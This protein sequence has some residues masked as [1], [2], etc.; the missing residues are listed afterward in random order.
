MNTLKIIITLLVLTI[1]TA[2]AQ[3]N[4]STIQ[5]DMSSNNMLEGLE[6]SELEITF[7]SMMIEHHKGAIDMAQW[8]LERTQNADIKA[9]AEAIIAAQDPEIEQMTAWL[10]AWYKQGVD[11]HS[12]MMMQSEMDL[13]MGNMAAS[14]N[15]DAAFLQ[16]MSAHHNSAI[17]MAQF[18]LLGATHPELRELAKNIIVTQSQEI[19]QYQN[20]LEELP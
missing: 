16:E 11:Q 10:Q 7:L 5:M 18:A 20:W 14:T 13:M 15:P 9:A 1:G 19:A 4:M 2:F 6:N 17:D 12:V 8:I 3:D